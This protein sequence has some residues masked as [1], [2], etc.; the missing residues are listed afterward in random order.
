M[1]EL[2]GKVKNFFERGF[3]FITPSDG[4][5]DLFFHITSVAGDDD[6]E[7]EAGDEVEY[8]VGIGRDGRTKAELV[9]L[10]RDA[11]TEDLAREKHTADT[12]ETLDKEFGS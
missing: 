6:F 1:S 9:I 12:Q 10:N 8:V 4:G 11:A 2:H 5:E 7:P 3:G